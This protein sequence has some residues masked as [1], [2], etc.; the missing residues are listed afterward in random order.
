M[1]FFF[2]IPGMAADGHVMEN[3]SLGG[4]ESAGMYMSREL[5]RRGHK[6]VAFTNGQPGNWHGVEIAPIGQPS[7]QF[8]AGEN[9][10][11]RATTEPHDVLIAQRTPAPFLR[12]KNCRQAYMSMHDLARVRNRS[13]IKG[14]LWNCDGILAVSD[15]H[16]N[17]IE[18]VYDLPGE[19]VHTI[20]NGID[21]SLFNK[22]PDYERKFRGKKLVYQSR[23]ERGLR[24]LVEEDGIMEQLFKIDRDIT[25]V[26]C[27]YDNTT[28]EM[29]GHYRQLWQRCHELP[30]VELVGS[31]NKRTL[32]ELL[33][34][35][36]LLVYPVVPIAEH[37]ETSCI[38]VMEAQAAGTPVITMD[39]GAIF[40]TS[41]DPEKDSE[42]N[43]PGG[44]VQYA[45]E[46]EV[47]IDLFSS[48]IKQWLSDEKHWKKNAVDAFERATAYDW[49]KPAEALEELVGSASRKQTSN[50]L[51]LAKHFAYN[52][53]R[54]ALIKLGRQDC[55]YPAVQDFMGGTQY[56]DHGEKEIN[57]FYLRENVQALEKGDLPEMDKLS[58]IPTTN[59]VIQVLDRVYLRGPFKLLDYGCRTGVL[60]ALLA[61]RY[62]D[63]TFTGADLSPE[64]IAEANKQDVNNLKF[65]VADHPTALQDQFDVVLCMETLEHVLDPA[66]M[67]D[68]LEGLLK[69]FG[70]MLLTF[71]VGP[72]EASSHLS[73]SSEPYEHINHLEWQDV[74][75]MWGHKD[76]FTQNFFAWGGK[77][78]NGATIGGQVVT[79]QRDSDMDGSKPVDWDRK[80]VEQAPRETLSVCMIVKQ[81]S[82]TLERTIK[83][84]VNVADEIVIGVDGNVDD[85]LIKD[86]ALSLYHWASPKI[87]PLSASPL[88]QG[89]D[90]ARNETLERATC[91]WVLWIDSDEEL[92]YPERILKYLRPNCYEAYALPHHH[93]TAEPAGLLKTDYP[94][95]LF[96]QANGYQFFGMVH[97]HPSVAPDVI[98]KHVMVLGENIGISHTGYLNEEVRR[99]RFERN[100]PL[101]QKD[102]EKYP[103]RVLGEFLFLR[104]LLHIAKFELE[105]NNNQITDKVREYA[106]QGLA[107][108][109][110]LIELD[111]LRFV[112]ESLPY[113]GEAARILKGNDVVVMQLA[114]GTRHVIADQSLKQI[115]PEKLEGVFTDSETAKRVSSL[116]INDQ[117]KPYEEKYL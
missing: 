17:Q 12:P 64:A 85:W 29:E 105:R 84:L 74:R 65:V 31:L 93:L 27:G 95:R 111:E 56:A 41:H 79:W 35:A 102:R 76:N 46:G 54:A 110:R 16:K 47:N 38:S 18:K 112:L 100:W 94:T 113:V 66:G 23:P 28:P 73:G 55:I 20:R 101:M 53:D 97:E 75:D 104:D 58:G 88:E 72:S 115:I 109:D 91:D 43:F 48:L 8:P 39:N 80:M 1:K 4:S 11:R 60:T 71:P 98:P 96:R 30:N 89:F 15:W 116:L 90:A 114:V 24:H 52:S 68:G 32:A 63:C 67:A 45:D 7:E 70:T 59:M 87:F 51:R 92:V 82:S 22:E 5:V 86:S 21:L 37:E 106:E 9:F 69:P 78:P 83:S 44:I 117:F 42:I 2:Y 10:D 50:E 99:N 14:S 3:L 33:R 13:Q 108:F 107:I 6:V 34:D 49:S 61:L 103:Q 26:V 36:T 62:P 40:E 77:A 19:F 57:A 25:L 81:G